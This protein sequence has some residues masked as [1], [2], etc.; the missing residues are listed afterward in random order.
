MQISPDTV[1]SKDVQQFSRILD[2]ILTERKE[3]HEPKKTFF[4]SCPNYSVI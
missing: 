4:S 1:Q 3:R 2:Q